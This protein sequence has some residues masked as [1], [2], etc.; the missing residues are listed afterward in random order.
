ML[1]YI[2]IMMSVR[3]VVEWRKVSRENTKSELK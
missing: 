3:L 1:F 2:L